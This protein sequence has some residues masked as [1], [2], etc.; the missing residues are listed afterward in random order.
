[1]TLIGE[2]PAGEIATEH[3]VVSAATEAT[4]ALSRL[5]EYAVASTDANIP[6]SRGI[7]AIA[8]GGGGAGGETHTM[9]EWFENRDGTRGIS[10]A[11]LLLAAL[12]GNR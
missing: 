7:P 6:M 4:R 1:L 8:I 9:S 2:R 11:A 5:P 3:E 10:R 12:S